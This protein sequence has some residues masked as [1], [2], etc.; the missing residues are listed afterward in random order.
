MQVLLSSDVI[1]EFFINRNIYAEE[2]KLI[3]D[4]IENSN[5]NN[6]CVTDNCLDKIRFYMSKPDPNLGNEAAS[7][8]E[9]ISSRC[10]FISREHI[11]EARSS[12]LEN[13][14]LAV[15]AICAKAN[16]VNTIITLKSQ[17]LDDDAISIMSI[18]QFIKKLDI[19]ILDRL[20]LS[21]KK[22]IKDSERLPGISK[23]SSVKQYSSKESKRIYMVDLISSNASG[24]VASA[25]REM[26]IENQGLIRP[27]GNCYPNRRMAA[28]LR[29]AEIILRYIVYAFLTNNSSI[30]EDRCLNGL[31]PTYTAL[32]VPINCFLNAVL[33]IRNKFIALLDSQS[34][35]DRLDVES[36][37]YSALISEL[38]GYFDSVT[39]ALA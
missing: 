2:L 9:K 3:F 15:E 11:E 37:D 17:Y 22:Y 28:C 39:Y 27:G 6:F 7:Y 8:I 4:L 12:S 30:L 16:T 26:I 20:S 34:E 19:D 23:L 24:I 35:Q 14:D 29:D 36:S 21:A 18:N 38:T 13:F 25:T 10:L 5:I 31:R 32:G 33:N 1:L